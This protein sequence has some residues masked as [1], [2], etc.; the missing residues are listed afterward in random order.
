MAKIGRPSAYDQ[1]YP[2]QAEKLCLLGATDQEI[3]DFFEVDVRT[4]YRWKG[5]HEEFCQALK[6]GKE[7]ADAR[8]ERRSSAMIRLALAFAAFPA[9][10]LAECPLRAEQIA[11]LAEKYSERPI[12]AGMVADGASVLEVYAAEDGSWTLLRTTPDG[13]ACIVAF[14]QGWTAAEQGEPV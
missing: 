11:M 10:A 12:G 13:Q 4:I 6:A 9:A 5:L 1:S 14:G 7:Q 3:A 8:V 2:K